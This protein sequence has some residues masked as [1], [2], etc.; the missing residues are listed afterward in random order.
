MSKFKKPSELNVT[1]TIKALIY[2]QPGLGKS[3]L[4]LSTPSPVLLDFDGGVQRVN[5][6]FQ[7]DTLQ[8]T[9]WDDVIDALKEDL[10]P[11]KTI[12]IDTAGKM[13]DFMSDFIIK[14]DP[15]MKMRD[16]S[17]TL[18]GYG[19]RKAM[20]VNFLKDVGMLGKHIIFVAHEKEDK[21][22]DVRY[23]R[24]EMSGSAQGDLIKELDLV[25]YMQ[26]V[27]TERTI[28]WSPQEKFY[29][30]NTCNLPSWQ[31]VPTIINDAGAVTGENNFLTN[32]FANYEAYLEKQK[33][34]RAVYDSVVAKIA[35]VVSAIKSEDEA[36]AAI[37]EIANV[38]KEAGTPWDS[39]IRAKIMLQERTKALGLVMDKTSKKYVK[40]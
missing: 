33:D 21:D 8:V 37:T 30:K 5:G 22:G 12:V 23:V 6:A 10:S 11:Y 39:G 20:F 1:T 27:G 28:W 7:C 15:K 32:V 2:G 19:A 3:T 25:G 34:T 36:N 26:A 35:N 4:A 38:L 29:A 13:L 9:S 31:K 40:A 24:P 17:L 18:K 14:N 16:G